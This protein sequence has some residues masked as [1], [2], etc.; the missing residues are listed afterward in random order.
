MIV[1]VL[2]VGS[3]ASENERNRKEGVLR[4]QTICLYQGKEDL[5]SLPEQS[6]LAVALSPSAGSSIFEGID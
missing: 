5:S 2:H 4:L 6:E 1:D 3:K